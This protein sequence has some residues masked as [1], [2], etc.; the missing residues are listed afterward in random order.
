MFHYWKLFEKFKSSHLFETK[1][2]I[3]DSFEC[4]HLVPW[5]GLMTHSPSCFGLMVE[6]R[7]DTDSMNPNCQQ[8]TVQGGNGS[9]T[10]YAVFMWH[11]LGL[12]VHLN[13]LLTSNTY[14]ATFYKYLHPF[15]YFQHD[16]I[17]LAQQHRHWQNA[18]K[19]LMEHTQ[20]C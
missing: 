9:I 13:V 14:I 20:G 10:V 1:V 19:H 7:Y 3:N 18:K 11:W 17:C 6:I 15:M 12:V 5:F 8:C 16:G 4:R 2:K